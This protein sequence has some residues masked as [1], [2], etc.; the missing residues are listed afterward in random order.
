MLPP[1]RE[2]AASLP[3][4][5]LNVATACIAATLA[6]GSVAPAFC[7]AA[8]NDVPA[9]SATPP[10]P[11][12]PG[13]IGSSRAK[14]SESP[15]TARGGWTF[16]LVDWA[17][18][19][20]PPNATAVFRGAHGETRT[21]VRTALPSRIEAP[22]VIPDASEL[23]IGFALSVAPFMVQSPELAE[24]TRLRIQFQ[25]DGA[26][27]ASTLLERDLDLRENPGD[28]RWFDERID[29]SSLAGQSGRLVFEAEA[30]EPSDNLKYA[31]VLWSEARVHAARSAGP[32]LL[33]I[34][35][36][37]LRA[38]HLGSYGYTRDVSPRLDGLSIQGIR[39][40]NA[41]AGAP[42]TLPSIPQ[43]FTSRLFPSRDHPTLVSPLHEG[44][45]S[46]AAIVN[47]AW[48][49]LWFSQGRHA[50]P[51][52]T[53]DRMISGE[54][55][56]RTITDKAL[57][58][59]DEHPRQRFAL[60]LHYL[61]AHTPYRPPPD[62]VARYADPDYDGP[63]G[64]TFSD[65]V[66]ADEGRYDEADRKRIIALYDASIRMIDDQIG[67]VL[68]SLRENE[69]L[70]ET[71]IVISADHGEEF[72]DHG[73]FFHGQS[74]YDELLHIPLIVRLPKGAQAGTVIERP[75]SA[76]DIAP[77]ILEWL[78]LPL[79]GGFAGASLQR[80]IE[81]PDEEG[82]P[83]LATATQAQFPTRYAIRTRERK[84]IESLDTGDRQIFDLSD[85]PG[86][87]RPLD[88]DDA[89][90]EA[91]A[92]RLEEAR[93]ILEE[94]GYQVRIVGPD[95]ARFVLELE[96]HPRGGTFL[97]VDRRSSDREA[98]L[99]LSPDGRNLR[100]AASLEGGRAGLRFDRL[101]NPNR[102][103][104]KDLVRVAATADD[105]PV[106]NADILL[107]ATGRPP[108]TDFVDLQNRSI[109]AAAPPT[110][111]KPATGIRICIWRSPGEKLQALPEITDPRVRERLRA[112]GYLQ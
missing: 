13:P 12:S 110:C 28:R 91:L 67:R 37:C 21:A 46:T 24:P 4:T 94:S 76:L 45:L 93:R 92:D 10:A 18:R 86:E 78:D 35:I 16:D 51:P 14:I 99:R 101:P 25:P 74:L 62:L 55:D 71:L 95:G 85:D 84:L 2:S 96:G 36:D 81:D 29:L 108:R 79:P 1:M 87:R 26:G 88:P 48:I 5:L 23:Q 53:F 106:A 8:E 17:S 59:L 27:S 89:A 54:L 80:V 83:V 103:N 90:S 32:N 72:W 15:T 60:Y 68:D 109:D 56:A 34:T 52:G 75:V 9:G 38:D 58:W 57:A 31:D 43:I 11:G 47:N 66:G 111:E 39:F 73:R 98:T 64:D 49:P 42:M 33:F 69:R 97:T 105:Q 7:M 19:A 50:E 77:S 70:D 6:S 22:L 82:N 40:A 30:R 100:F 3:A 41:F 63:I 102:L 20:Q 107:G 44:G 104:R 61:D 112:L 65:S